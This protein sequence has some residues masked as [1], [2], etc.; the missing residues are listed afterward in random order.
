MRRSFR[1]TAP[2]LWSLVKALVTLSRLAP[3]MVAKLPVGVVGGYPRS[4]QRHNA[5]AFGELE[6]DVSQAGGH[7]LEADVF[8]TPLT[9]PKSLTKDVHHP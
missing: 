6:D 2:S 3:I 9:K 8:E 7:V 5:F 4:L 1:S